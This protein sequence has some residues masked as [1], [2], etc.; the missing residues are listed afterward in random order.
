MVDPGVD[1]GNQRLISLPFLPLPRPVVEMYILPIVPIAGAV[2]KDTALREQGIV[3]TNWVEYMTEASFKTSIYTFKI[4]AD[5]SRGV[6]VLLQPKTRF[7][8][9]FPG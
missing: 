7:I 2:F 8:C 5:G 1:P 6:L 9:K 3:E 4:L